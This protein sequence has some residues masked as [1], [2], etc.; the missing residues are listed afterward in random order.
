LTRIILL[1]GSSGHAEISVLLAVP[2]C[3]CVWLHLEYFTFMVQCFSCSDRK[4]KSC[5]F[6]MFVTTFDLCYTVLAGNSCTGLGDNTPVYM[7]TVNV[8]DLAKLIKSQGVP[9]AQ[10]PA[11]APMPVLNTSSVEQPAFPPVS[12]KGSLPGASPPPGS[13]PSA[14]YA[15]AA[16]TCSLL[17][18]VCAALLI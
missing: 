16:S 15:A 6:L 8:G 1:L 3:V 9:G 17:L 2:F 11:V 14:A 5:F 10:P 18:A 7:Q 12:P 13:S 4:L